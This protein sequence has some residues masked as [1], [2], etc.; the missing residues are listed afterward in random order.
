MKRFTIILF[1]L[2]TSVFS[3]AQSLDVGARAG[4]SFPVSGVIDQAGL[5]NGIEGFAYY[6]FN[7]KWSVGLEYGSTQFAD[8]G[9]LP[10]TDNL[11]TTSFQSIVKI[12]GAVNY[13]FVDSRNIR[14]GVGLGAGLMNVSYQ[15]FEETYLGLTPR[16]TTRVL[17]SDN[18]GLHGYV[19]LNLVLGGDGESL[20]FLSVQA[21]LFY[22]F[23]FD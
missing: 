19:P 21:G 9:E 15:I 10:W 11:N 14:M 23:N 18:F 22:R 7:G 16:L 20:S 3:F 4:I 6:N 17:L 12:G 5:G 2:A 8:S 13:S 1:I